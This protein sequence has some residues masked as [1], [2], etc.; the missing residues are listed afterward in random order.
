MYTLHGMCLHFITGYQYFD[1]LYVFSD[2]VARI[3]TT[4]SERR[5]PTEE[6]TVSGRHTLYFSTVYM[7]YHHSS[8]DL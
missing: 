4:A 7:Y 3:F 6:L 1:I 2:G 5:A 8:S